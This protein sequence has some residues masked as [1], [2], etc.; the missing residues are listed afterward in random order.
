MGK[1]DNNQ[2]EQYTI[3]YVIYRERTNTS[4]DV[5]MTIYPQIEGFYYETIPEN[6]VLTAAEVEEVLD[7][8]DRTLT[9]HWLAQ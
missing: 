8:V 7:N 4:I 5:V 9:A 3:T 1:I 2:L 6:V